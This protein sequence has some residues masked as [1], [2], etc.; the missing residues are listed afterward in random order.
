MTGADH[1]LCFRT[2]RLIP[3]TTKIAMEP[4]CN[5]TQRD[6]CSRMVDCWGFE[7]ILLPY[8]AHGVP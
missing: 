1:G 8:Q 5:V 7:A 2:R 4:L 3:R 6:L